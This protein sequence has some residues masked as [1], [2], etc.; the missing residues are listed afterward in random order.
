MSLR[1]F[2]DIVNSLMK[3]TCLGANT[4]ET[5]HISFAMKRAAKFIHHAQYSYNINKTMHQEIDF[6]H[7]KLQPLSDISWEMPIAH[8]RP[9]MHTATAFGDSCL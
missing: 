3:G 1:E 4:N 5:G 2:Q 7:K 9:R 6:F 8:I